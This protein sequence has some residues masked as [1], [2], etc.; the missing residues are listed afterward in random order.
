MVWQGENAISYVRSLVGATSPSE[1]A[2]GTIRADFGITTGNNIIHASDGAETSDA[3]VKR[4]FKENELLTYE[5][6]N[7]SWL[8][9]A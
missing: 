5:L 8:G 2:P 3:E 6:C 9:E 4:F 1:A 7:E